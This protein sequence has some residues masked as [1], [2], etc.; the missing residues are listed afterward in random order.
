MVEVKFKLRGQ[1]PTFLKK[2]ATDETFRCEIAVEA[3]TFE[4]CLEIAKRHFSMT[5]KIDYYSINVCSAVF[6]T[7]TSGKVTD[8]KFIY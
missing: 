6:L 8:Y 5:E 3:E 7:H 2:S 4:L 1:Y